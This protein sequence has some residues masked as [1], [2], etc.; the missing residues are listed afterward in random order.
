[1]STGE[2]VVA[3]VLIL[4]L[5]AV[6][7]YA[8]EARKQ[9]AA[10][11]RMAEEMREQRLDLDRPYLLLEVRNLD[12]LD[13]KDL[14][15]PSAAEPDPGAAYPRSMTYRVHNAGRGPAKE[16]VTTV[17]QPLVV[18]DERKRDVLMPGDFWHVEAKAS[19]VL[20]LLHEGTTGEKPL[21]ME[22]WMKAQGIHSAFYGGAYDCGLMAGCTDIHDRRWA[23]YLKFGLVSSTDTVRKVVTSRTLVPLEHRIVQLEG[24]D[25]PRS[26]RCHH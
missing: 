22:R 26:H 8:W 7:W 18:F 6:L 17:L 12:A 20:A 23:T 14:N 10:S 15:D 1:M 19:E 13:W 2:W 9:A 5:G 21:G 24:D 4:T 16:I 11:L 3:V 25:D